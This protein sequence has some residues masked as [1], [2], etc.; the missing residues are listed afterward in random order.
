[1]KKDEGQK[2]LFLEAGR[3][4]G[5]SFYYF[6]SSFPFIFCIFC[7]YAVKKTFVINGWSLTF[8]TG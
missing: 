1:M 4:E 7:T 8:L 3:E 2:I 5:I 6:F